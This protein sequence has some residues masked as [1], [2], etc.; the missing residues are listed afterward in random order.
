MLPQAGCG[1]GEELDFSSVLCSERKRASTTYHE[2]GISNPE[3]PPSSWAVGDG[4]ILTVDCNGDGWGL[5]HGTAANVGLDV[6]L[7]HRHHGQRG[8]GGQP[9]GLVVAAGIV[10]HITRVAVQEGHGAEPS[11]AGARQPCGKGPPLSMPGRF[12][13]G[14]AKPRRSPEAPCQGAVQQLSAGAQT[15][16]GDRARLSSSMF[17]RTALGYFSPALL[18]VPT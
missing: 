14:P 8:S 1:W 15:C 12:P 4:D 16:T 10:A 13:G 11:Q 9:V 17:Q 3:T 2:E 18:E 5:A 7:G 6:I